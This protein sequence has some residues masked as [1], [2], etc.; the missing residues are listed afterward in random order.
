MFVICSTG[1]IVIYRTDAWKS[2]RLDGTAEHIREVPCDR[3]RDVLSHVRAEAF[4]T[5]GFLGEGSPSRA[6][7]CRGSFA[8]LVGSLIGNSH[9]MRAS[10]CH[11]QIRVRDRQR[12]QRTCPC[13]LDGYASGAEMLWCKVSRAPVTEIDKDVVP[14]ANKQTKPRIV[15]SGQK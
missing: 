13:V 10:G 11:I 3:A 14:I 8:G 15:D 9:W 4:D 5:A 1:G 2:P 6:I 12:E 7:M